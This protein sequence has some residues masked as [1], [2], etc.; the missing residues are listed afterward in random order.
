MFGSERRPAR[1]KKLLDVALVR[2]MARSLHEHKIVQW[3]LLALPPQRL[4]L[5]GG[6]REGD[7]SSDQATKAV[8]TIIWQILHALSVR[9]IEKAES[10]IERLLG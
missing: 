7:M 8:R 10:S 2:Q 1:E 9:D 4:E 5:L 6:G 3:E